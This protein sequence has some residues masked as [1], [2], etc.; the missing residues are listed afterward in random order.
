[1]LVDFSIENFGPFKNKVSVSLLRTA[2]EELPENLLRCDALVGDSL[3][4]SAILF[5]PNSSGKS[6]IIYAVKVLQAMVSVPMPANYTYPWYR[7]YRLSAESM[8]KPTTIEIRF[9]IGS[10]L[11]DYGVSFDRNHIVHEHLYQYPSGHKNLVFSRDE[12]EF[13]IGRNVSR[14]QKAITKM[15]NPCSTYLSVAAQFNNEI[16]LSAHKVLTQDIL[17]VAGNPEIQLAKAATMLERSQ[18]LRTLLLRALNIADFGITDIMCNV[19]Y[20]APSEFYGID[21]PETGHEFRNPDRNMEAP[22]IKMILKHDFMNPDMTESSQYFPIQIESRGTKEMI[23]IMTPVVEAL[24]TGKIVFIDEFGSNLHPEVARWIITQFKRRSNPNRAQ[25]LMCS[26]DHSIMDTKRLFRRDQIF[27]TR[28]ES[29][30][31]E[32]EIYSL[33]DF[34]DA[35]EDKTDISAKASQTVPYISLDSIL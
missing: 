17:I 7:P 11:F 10:V 14:G 33:Y 19:N 16:C 31:G 9:T 15:T 25:L 26:N 28:R 6:S 22:I 2:L 3:L 1:M 32:V 20:D 18:Q 8:L 21:V 29:H 4:N 35:F 23:T 13:T 12:Q 27:F 34:E 24:N 5:G 30:S